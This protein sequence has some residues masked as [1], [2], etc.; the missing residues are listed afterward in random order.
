VEKVRI[1]WFF[2]ILVA[3]IVSSLVNF[4]L[5][6]PVFAEGGIAI[7]GSFYK[8]HFQ[9]LPGE[10]ISSPDI[11]VVVFNNYDKEINVALT[12]E[13]PAGI[14]VNFSQTTLTIPAGKNITISMGISASA[15]VVPGDYKL[16]VSAA[17]IPDPSSGIVIAGA[18]ALQADLTIFGEA[19]SANITTIT[20]DGKPLTADLHL[21]RKDGDKLTPAGF[22]AS[23]ILATRLV[24]GDYK[25]QVFYKDTQVASQDFSVAANE[26]KDVVITAQTVFLYGF[27]VVPVRDENTGE[28]SYVN[29]NYTLNNIYLPLKDLTAK[30]NVT[31]NGAL[32][33]T[34]VII[35]IPTLDVGET[36]GTYKY[37]PPKGW[38]KG[39][40]MFRMSVFSL[41]NLYGQSAEKTVENDKA[42]A[43]GEGETGGGAVGFSWIIIVIILVIALIGL[44]LFFYIKKL[45][46][47][48]QK[49]PVKKKP[50]I[51]FEE[52]EQQ[53]KKDSA[54]EPKS[55]IE[56]PKSSISSVQLIKRL[57]DSRKKTASEK[58]L[59][60]AKSPGKKPEKPAIALPPEPEKK[61]AKQLQ[62]DPKEQTVEQLPPAP[63][64]QPAE[65]SPPTP[66]E[67]LGTQP[68]ESETVSQGT[69]PAFFSKM[70][71]EPIRDLITK[72]LASVKINYL[73]NN[74]ESGLP[75]IRVELKVTKNN[76][77][78]DRLNI[79][80]IKTPVKGE[81]NT[82]YNYVPREGW[83]KEA[84]YSFWLTL[85]RGKKLVNMSPVKK[86]KA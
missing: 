39:T 27:S 69:E 11:N 37:I 38:Q 18:A 26:H 49:K 45:K 52:P 29:I 7:S 61:P 15:D 35:T 42:P 83:Q 68:N 57:I 64:E 80:E 85:Y 23:G 81:N 60:P 28:L 79:L 20:P 82:S 13:T 73:I 47:D 4:A 55:V 46:K 6:L 65:V 24:P 16:A 62:P 66:K 25:V 9:I 19:G 74:P 17:V 59:P 21:Y 86:L 32:V 30:L 70:E 5:P 67:Q 84:E 8:Q 2:P 31:L 63:T 41:G 22:S 53:S 76:L 43:G 12:S 50:V 54:Q 75:N 71:L 40:Y 56:E 34:A 33:E 78:L 36:S 58:T 44:F 48:S 10:T 72:E 51:H 14:T 77:L 1:K 3:L